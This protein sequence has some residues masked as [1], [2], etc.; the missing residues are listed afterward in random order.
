[1]H[2]LANVSLSLAAI[3]Q[4][5]AA[6]QAEPVEIEAR[7][8]PACCAVS[9]SPLHISAVGTDH[10]IGGLLERS[11]MLDMDSGDSVTRGE[12]S[13]LE[14]APR[15]TCHSQGGNWPLSPSTQHVV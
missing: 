15:V 10:P 6:P 14:I 12:E 13:H 8:Q 7:A 1:M 2:F 4:A 11:S 5:A 3:A 9:P